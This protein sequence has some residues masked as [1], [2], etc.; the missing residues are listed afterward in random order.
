[1][2]KGPDGK[3]YGC[4]RSGDV[5]SLEHTAVSSFY[6]YE[7]L[8]TT[9]ITALF[10]DPE[11]KGMVYIGTESNKIYHGFF[12]D[13]ID[14]MKAIDV[15]PLLGISWISEECGHIWVCSASKAGYLDK[16]A[17]FHELKNLPMINALE[18]MTSDYQ[19]NIWA[20]SSTQGV[21]KIVANNFVNVSEEAKLPKITVNTTCKHNGL[22]YIGTETGLSIIDK[23]YQEI[24]N[25]L[26]D[27]MGDARIRCIIEDN[28]KNIWLGTYTNDMGLVCQSPD[29]K[30]T[31]FTTKNGL[32]DNRIRVMKASKDNSILC[33]TN[34][35]FS[36]IKN[37]KVIKSIGKNDIVK[38]TVFLTVEE[39]EDGKIYLGTDGD[40]IYI[41]SGS[42]I[43]RY[44]RDDG[45]TS[46]VVMR[47][48]E[49]KK[50]GVIWL[51]TS[52]SIQYMKG[53][54]VKNV[55]TFPYNNNYDVYLNDKNELWILSSYGI[56]SVNAESMIEDNISD[57]TL[58]VYGNSLSEGITC[59]KH[60]SPK[61]PCPISL[62]PGEPYLPVSPTEN[63]GKL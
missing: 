16:N 49:D 59:F 7:E 24:K 33:G 37:Q 56:Y 57:T 8:G 17:S 38:N 10:P 13:S 6:R 2:V 58:T 35:G 20:C 4:T 53:G 22:L 9:F 14:K 45:L 36:I 29:G 3:I 32:I 27:F 46:D 12:G 5:F 43:Q 44:G 60:L 26:T 62:L 40:G 42:V 48:K 41:V 23:D 11:K 21:M 47:I 63:A 51:V 19:G 55:T 61:A 15:S 52:N 1:M 28:E 31:S 18:M 54:R 39:S 50:N 25:E 30:I 34:D